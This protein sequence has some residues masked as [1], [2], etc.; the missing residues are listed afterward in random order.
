MSWRMW[1][2]YI[3]LKYNSIHVTFQ[4][5]TLHDSNCEIYLLGDYLVATFCMI[6]SYLLHDLCSMIVDMA[7]PLQSN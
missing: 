4:T 5:I 1:S 3:Q 2:A 7:A 6:S